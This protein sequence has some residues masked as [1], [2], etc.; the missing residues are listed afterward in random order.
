MF[1][2]P[3]GPF[4]GDVEPDLVSRGIW[5][6]KAAYHFADLEQRAEVDRRVSEIGHLS[7]GFGLLDRDGSPLLTPAQARAFVNDYD[8]EGFCI[9]LRM[10]AAALEACQRDLTQKILNGQIAICHERVPGTAWTWIPVRAYVGLQPD[11]DDTMAAAG[12]NVRLTG[13]LSFDVGAVTR[14]LTER[15]LTTDPTAAPGGRVLAD[16]SVAVRQGVTPIKK[17]RDSAPPPKKK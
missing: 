14:W 8:D 17:A 5:F 4:V 1:N 13:V 16:K 11:D 15:A 9:A 6:G 12:S 7:P 3:A 2:P 10:Y